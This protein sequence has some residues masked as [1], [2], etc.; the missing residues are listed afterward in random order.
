MKKQKDMLEVP[1]YNIEGRKVDTFKVDDEVFGSEVN[2]DLLKQAIVAYHANRHPGTAKTRGR[3][4]V[5]GSRHK[6]FRQKG[7]GFARRGAKRANILRGGGVTFAKSP[8]TTR[9]KLPRKMKKAALKS[10]VLAK[11]ISGDLMVLEDL[12]VHAPKTATI[13]D[14]LRK[15]SIDRSCLLALEKHDKNIYLSS[16]NIP[17][18]AV[19]AADELNAYDVVLKQKLVITAKAMEELV[20]RSSNR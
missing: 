3:S 20:N 5:K 2:A 17:D 18:L 4:D 11:I 15:M 16:R 9:K 7:T 10:A 19:C 8:K 14:M 1:V 12:S 6:M 13:A